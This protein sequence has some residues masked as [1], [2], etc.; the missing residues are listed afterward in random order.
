MGLVLPITPFWLAPTVLV[1]VVC[2]PALGAA[3]GLLCKLFLY[4]FGC[5]FCGPLLPSPLH[6]MYRILLLDSGLSFPCFYE[7]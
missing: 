1:F 5:G 3:G 2:P 4:T 6:H 7:H